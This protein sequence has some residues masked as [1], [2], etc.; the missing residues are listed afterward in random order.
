MKKVFIIILAALI[1]ALASCSDGGERE[2][3]GVSQSAPRETQTPAPSLDMSYAFE[4]EGTNGNVHKLSD[5]KGTP[6]YLEVWGSWC[7]VCVSALPEMNEFAGESHGFAVLSV[8][9]PNVAG[10]MSR[11]DFTEWYKSLGYD[12]LIVL[13]DE[14]AQI[15]N[16]FGVSA[17]PS[18]LMFDADGNFVSGYAGLIPKE[19]IIGIMSDIAEG[20]HR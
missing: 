5:Y 13:L 6:V 20:R 1:A 7:G 4:L 2:P 19:T 10:E 14:N 16:D 3:A 11:E 18:Q 15:V 17:Y 9:T 12:N 8:V